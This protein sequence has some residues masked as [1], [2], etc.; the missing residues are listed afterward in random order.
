MNDDKEQL[1]MT[2]RV[3]QRLLQFKKLSDLEVFVVRKRRVSAV[4]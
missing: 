1:V 3:R 2:Y 4:L